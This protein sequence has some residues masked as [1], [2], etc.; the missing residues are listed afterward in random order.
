MKAKP[1]T[2]VLDCPVPTAPADLLR[3]LSIQV[4]GYVGC[5][6]DLARATADELATAA[7]EAADA[8]ARAIG[9]TFHSDSATLDIVLCSGE[10]EVWRVSRAIP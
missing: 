4:L 1:F 2:F 6:D 8:G 5:G 3:D 9:V 7:A 10:R